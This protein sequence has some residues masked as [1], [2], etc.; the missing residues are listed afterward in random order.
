PGPQLGPGARDQ[1][2]PRYSP[3]PVGVC[4]RVP[5]VPVC[6]VARK[7]ARGAELLD[8]RAQARRRGI[9]FFEPARDE[10]LALDELFHLGGL[11]LDLARGDQAA[12]S[13][14]LELN[15]IGLGANIGQGAIKVLFGQSIRRSN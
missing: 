6:R 7:G 11:G 14:A 13:K 3:A 5:T 1:R 9:E 12:Y 10:L 4:Q 2:R 8:S 15:Q